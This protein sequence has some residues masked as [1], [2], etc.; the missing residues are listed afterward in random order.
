[1]Y[2][3]SEKINTKCMEMTDVLRVKSLLAR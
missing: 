2:N 1:M 3:L